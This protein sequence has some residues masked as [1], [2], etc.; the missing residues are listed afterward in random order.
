MDSAHV[1]QLTIGQVLSVKFA[2]TDARLAWVHQLHAEA[3]LIIHSECMAH[4]NAHAY[5]IITMLVLLL[6]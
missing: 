2:T 1:L 3:V 6:V 4:R 5:K